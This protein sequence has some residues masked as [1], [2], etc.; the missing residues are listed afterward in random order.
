MWSSF[1]QSLAANLVAQARRF[2]RAHP[3]TGPVV[4][5]PLASGPPC[6]TAA[7]VDG[8]AG[9][10]PPNLATVD[11]G[12]ITA[13][14]TITIQ[15]TC[16]VNALG[17][18]YST[19]YSTAVGSL[20]GD[21]LNGLTLHTNSALAQY[22]SSINDVS[23]TTLTP[24]NGDGATTYL[25][26]E[27]QPHYQNQVWTQMTTAQGTADDVCAWNRMVANQQQQWQ[28]QQL[29]LAQYQQQQHVTYGVPVPAPESAAAEVRARDLLD[30]VLDPAQ[31]D[32]M[33]QHRY[34]TV[35]GSTTKRRYRVHVDK[36]RHGNIT[37]VAENGQPVRRL[38]CAPTECPESDALVGQKLFLEMSEEE[39][40]RTANVTDLRN[41][42]V[43]AG[44]RFIEEGGLL[45]AG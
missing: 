45:R 43:V 6:V 15:G 22:Q 44:A 2:R 36:G 4:H 35:I 16:L 28:W 26:R 38:C 18:A 19:A 42:T 13:H 3:E 33:K 32:E 9:Y 29:Q 41:G 23:L 8:Y 30:T 40:V 31:R 27:D 10:V 12:A 11:F 21:S 25:M 17:A 1:L 20:L 24:T 34:F 37:E 14:T 5:I 39:F 7:D